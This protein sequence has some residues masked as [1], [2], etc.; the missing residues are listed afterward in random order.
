MPD[1]VLIAAVAKNG[2]IGNGNAIPWKLRGDMKFFAETT[3]GNVII[4]GRKTWDSLGQK[5]LKDRTHIVISSNAVVCATRE[6]LEA[7]RPVISLEYAL[8]AGREIAT[9]L[10]CK[11]FVIGGATVYEQTMGIADELIITHIEQDFDGDTFFPG[12]KSSEWA[13]VEY[14]RLEDQSVPN[15]VKRYRR[16]IGEPCT[17]DISLC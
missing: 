7:I 1:V 11:L 9:R 16:R 2:V 6:G 3:K 4:M 13:L 8:N 15:H 14:K 17:T 5:P 10:G 12:I